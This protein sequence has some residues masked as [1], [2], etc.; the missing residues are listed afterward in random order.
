MR[1]PNCHDTRILKTKDTYYCTT[2]S[3]TWPI[4]AAAES[5]AWSAAW[6]EYSAM[7]IVRL[8]DES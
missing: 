6:S 8:G 1:C 4:P 5:A 2:C 3:Y 7:L